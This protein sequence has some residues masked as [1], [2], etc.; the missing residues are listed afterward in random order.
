MKIARKGFTL[1]ELLVVIAIIAILAAILFP[2]FAKAR[3]KARQITCASNLKQ[4]GLAFAQYTQDY[5]EHYQHSDYW[6]S[7]Q[8][9]AGQIFPYV[10]ST[11][12][13]TCPDDPTHGNANGTVVSYACNSDVSYGGAGIGLAYL[14]APSSTFLLCEAQ[15]TIVNVT[16]TDE[17]SNALTSSP[18]SGF[19]SPATHG[20]DNTGIS[21]KWGGGYNPPSYV[22]GWN[23]SLRGSTFGG[24][25]VHTTGSNYLACDGHVKYL[26]P[27][28]VSY[29]G[30]TNGQP[31]YQD[32]TAFGNADCG[33]GMQAASVNNLTL[34]GPGSATFVLTASPT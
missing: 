3:E 16:V 13:F 34:S 26:Q 22:E 8:G 5:D 2:V 20:G 29:G 12:V 21:G 7:A 11:A 25:A 1:I 30:S 27:A 18:P 19:M 15:G 4:L 31:C 9:W 10:K 17:G 32:D 23:W 28:A 24:V 14:S 6:D 33:Y